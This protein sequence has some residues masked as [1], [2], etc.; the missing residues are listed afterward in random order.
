MKTTLGVLALLVAIMSGC[1]GFI[2]P[3]HCICSCSP[4]ADPRIGQLQ[5]ELA[6]T[7]AEIERLRQR[8]KAES[9]AEAEPKL[10]WHGPKIVPG[11]RP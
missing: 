10:Q 2:R 7:H 5:R 3:C 6:G 1:A 9:E 4:T 11:A 8:I